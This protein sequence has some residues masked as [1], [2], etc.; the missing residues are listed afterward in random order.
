M[1]AL[2]TITNEE[3]RKLSS[4]IEANYGIHLKEEKTALVTG[5]LQGELAQT[6]CGSFSEYYDYI[7]KDKT[8]RASINLL[9]RITTNHTFFMR[10]TEHFNYF[11]DTV[12]PYLVTHVRDHDLRIWSAGCAS[13]EEP[14]TLAMIIDEVLGEKR[15]GWDRQVLATDISNKALEAA[16][17]GVY[18]NDELTALP[19]AWRQ[20]YFQR[21]D[22]Q[23]SAIVDSL[24]EQVIFR[25]FNL[26][27]QSFSFRRKFQV[28]FCRNV[29][30]YFS[31][32]VK[33]ALLNRF[34][35]ATE[36][37][38]YLFVGHSESF[39]RDLVKYKFVKPA[40]YRKI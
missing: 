30:I 11:R 35:D 32:E 12:L 31:N 34:Y 18:G 36:E 39:N 10:E 7:I 17:R 1:S 20:K 25:S 29:M 13:G 3:F 27:N 4:Y 28:I 14:Y 23:S 9:N 40:I 16:R 33:T 22:E 19:A 24:K 5:R 37:G 15:A 21:H 8:G 2:I 38:G 6:K 26:M